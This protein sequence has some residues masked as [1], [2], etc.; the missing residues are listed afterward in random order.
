MVG[1]DLDVNESN[2]A[3]KDWLVIQTPQQ[4]FHDVKSIPF[5]TTSIPNGNYTIQVKAKDR[6][7]NTGV[8]DIVL[9]VDN[10]PNV[11]S[12]QTMGDQNLLTFEILV[13][14]GIASTITVFTLKRLKI[15]KRG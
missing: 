2:L 9:N 8:T 5:D 13:G 3:Q 10:S 6:A 1:F 4:V 7:G 15:S 14:I 12:G 11:I